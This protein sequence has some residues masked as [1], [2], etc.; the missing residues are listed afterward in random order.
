MPVSKNRRKNKIKT[1]SKQKESN[2]VVTVSLYGKNDRIASKLVATTIHMGTKKIKEMK[3]WYSDTNNDVRE[4]PDVVKELAA[5]IGK[6]NPKVVTSPDKIIGCPHEE[7]ID[8][9]ENESCP[10]C[11]FWKHR[12]RFSGELIGSIRVSQS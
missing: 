3:K 9:P 4:I 5:F 12:D 7:G 8:Y 10:E 6:W 1:T 11:T 2:L